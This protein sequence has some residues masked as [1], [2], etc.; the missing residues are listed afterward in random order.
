MCGN[1]TSGN[2]GELLPRSKTHYFY[3][4][5]QFLLPV[6]VKL[7]SRTAF[8]EHPFISERLLLSHDSTFK[9]TIHLPELLQNDFQH[10]PRVFSTSWCRS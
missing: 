5:E 10:E 1:L 7:K 8:L 6:Y 9:L 2:D 3:V 4:W